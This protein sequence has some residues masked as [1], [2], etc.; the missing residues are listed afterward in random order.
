MKTLATIGLLLVLAVPAGAGVIHNEPVDGD[1]SSNADAPTPLVFAV[2]GNTIIGTVSGSG[3]VDR[4]YITFAV[5]AAHR[6]TALNLL[7]Y[8]PTNISFA[9]LNAG[10]TSF[11]P[12]IANEGQFMSGIHISGADLG[13]NLMFAF[14]ANS[15]VSNSLPEPL[16]HPGQYSFVIQQVSVLTTSYSLEFVLESDPVPTLGTTWGAIKSLYQ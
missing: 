7:A 9:A 11:E 3:G 2:G 1:L 6:L 14:V 8:S 4:D 10:A 13:T 16:L 12:S 15:Q 5:P